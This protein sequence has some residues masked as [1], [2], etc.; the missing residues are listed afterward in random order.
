M[1]ALKHIQNSERERR[2]RRPNLNRAARAGGVDRRPVS[3]SGFL[4]EEIIPSESGTEREALR[5]KKVWFQYVK[6]GPP[7]GKL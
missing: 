7:R 3:T 2:P 5:R 4:S 6:W 1:T